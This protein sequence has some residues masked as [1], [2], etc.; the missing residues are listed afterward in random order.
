MSIIEESKIF[1]KSHTDFMLLLKIFYYYIT[2]VL[3]ILYLV[4]F[5]VYIIKNN[6]LIEFANENYINYFLNIFAIHKLYSMVYNN[7]IREILFDIIFL[8]F[9]IYD[10]INQNTIHSIQK[11]ILYSVLM[12]ILIFT[13][14]TLYM[15]IKSD[16]HKY[17]EKEDDNEHIEFEYI[18]YISSDTI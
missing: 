17:D 5:P 3:C 12:S 16:F 18:D 1:Y 6:N 7:Y 10:I 8:L 15:I 13:Y 4:W 2:Y 14:G 11:L 9:I